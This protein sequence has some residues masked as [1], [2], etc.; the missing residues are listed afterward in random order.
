[1]ISR[2]CYPFL[3]AA[4]IGLTY[5]LTARILFT[6]Q[7]AFFNS[8]TSGLLSIAFLF[9]M[10]LALG[11]ITAYFIPTDP[12]KVWRLVWAPFLAVLLFLTAAL[13]FH[14]EGLICVLI[15]S[16]LFLLMSFLGAYLY[17]ALENT[18]PKRPDKTL[19]V[20]VFAI[21]PFVA[22]PIEA[23]FNNPDD[24]RRVI[25]YRP[26]PRAGGRGVAAH[27]PRGPHSDPGLGP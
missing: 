12:S 5:S 18:R 9:V 4:G 13:L 27:Y 20:A 11:A 3:L 24:F 25:K 17:V 1:M 6:T 23:Q 22:A 26:H 8:L 19:V 14:L 16:P 21:L 7:F 10:P 15:I 2:H